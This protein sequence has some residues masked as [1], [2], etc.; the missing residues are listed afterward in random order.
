[1]T[2]P[3]PPAACPLPGAGPTGCPLYRPQLAGAAGTTACRDSVTPL[4]TL[5]WAERGWGVS[6]QTA[7]L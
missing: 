1:M 2:L 7:A 6:F 3:G 4:L 5:K